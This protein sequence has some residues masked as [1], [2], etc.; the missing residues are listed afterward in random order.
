[1]IN[2]GS[3]LSDNDT[4]L[5]RCSMSKGFFLNSVVDELK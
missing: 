5:I 2:G 3:E 1:M 4:C